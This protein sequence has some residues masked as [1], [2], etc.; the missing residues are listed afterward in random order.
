M[1]RSDAFTMSSTLRVPYEK[2]MALGGV[3]TGSMKA[4]EALMVQGSMTYRG[5][6]FIVVAYGTQT[7][8]VSFVHLVIWTIFLILYLIFFGCVWIKAIRK[9]IQLTYSRYQKHDML[10]RP[11]NH[12][13]CLR[14]FS[15]PHLYCT[16]CWIISIEVYALTIEARMGRKSVVVAVLLEHSVNVPTSRQ[17]SIEMANGGML[18]RGARLS[19]SHFDSPDT[20]K[21]NNIFANVQ[22]LETFNFN[23]K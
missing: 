5:W 13:H 7:F 14:T 20:W 6:R 3:A 1:W 11:Y 8:R 9:H 22:Y 19:P 2:A 23:W 17:S 4:M 16:L 15:F 21:N 12:N 10:Y 18:W